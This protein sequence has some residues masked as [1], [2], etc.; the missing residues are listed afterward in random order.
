MAKCLGMII[1][2]GGCGVFVPELAEAPS[3]S[4]AEDR[5]PPATGLRD[6]RIGV[7]SFRTG[8][9]RSSVLFIC[10]GMASSGYVVA[11]PYHSVVQYQ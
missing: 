9:C 4:F 7:W 3:C 1:T 6:V 8:A 5:H 10:G 2:G 11:G